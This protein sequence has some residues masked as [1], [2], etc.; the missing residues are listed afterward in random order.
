MEAGARDFASKY[1]VKQLD[2]VAFQVS[3]A[4]ARRDTEAIHDLRVAM[5]RFAQGLVVF[6]P[7][8]GS[9]KPKKIRR[10]LKQVMELAGAVRDYDVALASS[11]WGGLG[12]VSRKRSTHPIC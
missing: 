11:R 10:V 5:R 9:R 4:I 1:L 7:H 8:V 12:P 6:R 3:T 2:R